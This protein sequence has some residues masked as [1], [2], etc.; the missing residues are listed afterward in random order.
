MTEVIVWSGWVGGLAAG[1]YA[2]FQFALS[3][4]HL[5]VSTGFGNICSYISKLP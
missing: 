3:G 4:K 2:L 5:G 1:A